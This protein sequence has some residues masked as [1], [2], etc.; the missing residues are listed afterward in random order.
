MVQDG[1]GGDAQAVIPLPTC[2]EIEDRG[3]GASA[4]A[5][6]T[7]TQLTLFELTVHIQGVKNW[8][9]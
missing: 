2:V 7:S 9:T 3:M 6:N 5:N 8:Q 4:V 1:G